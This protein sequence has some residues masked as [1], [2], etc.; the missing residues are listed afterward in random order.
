MCQWSAHT[1]LW[2]TGRCPVQLR[3][4]TGPRGLRCIFCPQTP[5]TRSQHSCH[6]PSS[7]SLLL[8]LGTWQRRRCAVDSIYRRK[9]PR[10]AAAQRR[11]SSERRF[12]EAVVLELEARGAKSRQSW[13]RQSQSFGRCTHRRY[14]MAI[15]RVMVME[16]GGLRRGQTGGQISWVSVHRVHCGRMMRRKGGEKRTGSWKARM[17]CC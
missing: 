17:Q 15:R 1:R 4:D 10:T 3:A 11:Y 2:A 13:I 8:W 7:T 9:M 14:A 6:P 12:R 16:W 5:C